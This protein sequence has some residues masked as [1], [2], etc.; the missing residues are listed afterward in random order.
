MSVWAIMTS[1]FPVLATAAIIAL[2]PLL[3]DKPPV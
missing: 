2:I 1:A 3:A